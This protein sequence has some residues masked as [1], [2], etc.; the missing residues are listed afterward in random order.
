MVPETSLNRRRFL[1]GLGA[2]G[3]AL[4]SVVVVG[5]DRLR[6]SGSWSGAR[7]DSAAAS[8]RRL[9]SARA[10]RIPRTSRQGDLHRR[11]SAGLVTGRR[12]GLPHRRRARG[13]GDRRADRPVSGRQFRLRIQLARRRR[14]EATAAD[15]ARAGVELDG[16]ESVRHQR[17]HR[18]VPVGGHRAAAGNELRH[19]HG[20]DG[21]RL[22]RVLQLRA[23]HQ[24]ERSA[25]LARLRAAAQRALLVPRQRDGRAVA[26]RAAAGARVRPQGARRG[27]ADAR[28]RRQSAADRLRVERHEHAPIPDLG[29]GSAR[30]V[31]RP[32]RRHLAAR[33]LRQHARR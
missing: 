19:R 28:H 31:L 23:R 14:P 22:R 26:D 30:R 33:V 18:L 27:A 16:N 10:R 5:G 8:R 21:R 32:G 25:S 29:P 24:V 11:L 15:G 17:V 7:A 12:E 13:Q 9:R 20:G 2:T 1:A 6:T 3:A 4:A